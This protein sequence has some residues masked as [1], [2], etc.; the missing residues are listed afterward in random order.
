M[1]MRSSPVPSLGLMNI[2]NLREMIERCV[3]ESELETHGSI[4]LS[5]ILVSGNHFL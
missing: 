1:L 4:A 5:D 3:E 2:M